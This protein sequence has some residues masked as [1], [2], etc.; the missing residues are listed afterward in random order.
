MGPEAKKRSGG[1]F[2]TTDDVL[3]FGWQTIV[4]T[5]KVTKRVT[6]ASWRLAFASKDRALRARQEVGGRLLARD[7]KLL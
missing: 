3:L 2:L 7:E 1:T 5:N 4:C 6:A